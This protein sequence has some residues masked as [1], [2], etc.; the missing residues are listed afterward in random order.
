MTI[1][2][3]GKTFITGGFASR[4]P[5]KYKKVQLNTEIQAQSLAEKVD[6]ILEQL[7]FAANACALIEP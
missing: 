6:L 4:D 7:H 3:K 1:A 2:P 5:T